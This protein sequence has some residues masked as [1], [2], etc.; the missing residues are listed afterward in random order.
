MNL[1]GQI[2]QVILN[3]FDK[4]SIDKQTEDNNEKYSKEYANTQKI[5]FNA[6][7]AM[8]LT[9]RSV[10]DSTF[11]ITDASGDVSRRAKWLSDT[12]ANVWAKNKN[13]VSQ[14]LGT[15]GKVL[16]PYIADGKGY[17]DIVDQSRM[18]ISAMHGDEIASATILAERAKAS[19]K[20]Y[21]RFVD[22]TLEGTTHTIVTRATTENGAEVPLDTVAAW[23]S[24]QPEIVI[25]N[26]EHVLFGYLKC[27]RDNRKDGQAY[28]VPITYGCDE[29]K[30]R[31]HKCLE[32]I[33]REFEVKKAFIS[34]DSRLFGK[35]DELPKNGLFKKLESAAGLTGQSLWE[36]FDPAIRDSSYFALLTQLSAQLEMEVGTSPGILTAPRTENATA[37][38]IKQANY[39]TFTMIDDIRTN[40]ETA[41]NRT[42]YALDVLCE[43]FGITPAG[44]RGDFTVT[45][46]WDMSLLEDTTQTWQQMKDGY[47]MRIRSKAEL[48]SWQTGETLEDAQKA[49]DEIAK[50]DPSMA[51]LIGNAE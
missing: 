29:T 48:R 18:R 38:E 9:I 36:V 23:A 11:A 3:Y 46:D 24:I 34:A 43:Y 20:T 39:G 12:L 22:Y 15:G 6:I 51:D 44:A 45:Y 1:F 5:S 13:T 10:S 49:V 47:S 41:Y 32:D 35:G 27:P 25:E 28:G 31:L 42:V 19:G 8:A 16:I 37:T 4:K 14:A 30:R 21:Y 50:T 40:I 17:V 33:D 26:V 7:F 2:W